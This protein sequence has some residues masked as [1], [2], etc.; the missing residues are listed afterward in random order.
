M[1]SPFLHRSSSFFRSSSSLAF[2][3]LFEVLFESSAII[4]H[5][6]IKSDYAAPTN[7][8]SMSLTCELFEMVSEPLPSDKGVVATASEDACCRAS[9]GF[10]SVEMAYQLSSL[11]STLFRA[12]FAA[13]GVRQVRMLVDQVIS[14]LF[15]TIEMLMA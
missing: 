9:M 15:R 13:A 7:N 8:F 11:P 3:T 5:A 1:Y 10:G 4:S 2:H 12:C 6:L 14:K